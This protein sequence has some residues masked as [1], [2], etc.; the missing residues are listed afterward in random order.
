MDLGVDGIITDRPD[1]LHELMAERGPK[2][3]K[4]YRAPLGSV[5]S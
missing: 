4:R 1:W 3:P 5:L 2:L